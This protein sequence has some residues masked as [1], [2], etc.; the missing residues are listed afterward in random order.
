MKAE[1]NYQGNDMNLSLIPESIEEASMLAYLATNVIKE[2]A[3][4]YAKIGGK[5]FQTYIDIPMKKN[6]PK[7][8]I[9]NR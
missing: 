1:I 4:V 5:D 8:W 3:K 2:P 7:T 6:N 9:E